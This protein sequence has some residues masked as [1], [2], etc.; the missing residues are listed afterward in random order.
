M[1]PLIDADILV[2]EVGSSAEYGWKSGGVPHFDY[3][4]DMLEEKIK[5]ICAAV[6]ATEE[7]ILFLSGKTN[8][9]YDIAKQIGYKANRKPERRP[10]HYANIRA[11]MMARWHT[12]ESVDCEAD[13][14][15]AVYQM[16]RI[17]E[18]DTIICSRDKDLKTVPGFHYSWALGRQQEFPPTWVDELGDVELHTRT[19]VKKDGTKS[20]EYKITGTGMKFFFVQCIIGDKADNIPGLAG[21]GCKTAYKLINKC[22]TVE[23]CYEA[24]MKAYTRKHRK[25]AEEMFIEQ[26]QLLWMVRDIEDNK[27]VMFTPERYVYRQKN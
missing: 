16:K 11:Y 15:L 23:Q 7:P 17:E 25:K 2:Y 4:A 8:F 19:K 12:V 18:K 27:L 26:A 5:N 9:R 24:V 13:D 21:S 20:Y 3:V 6:W 10:Y 1:Q 14:L 22:K